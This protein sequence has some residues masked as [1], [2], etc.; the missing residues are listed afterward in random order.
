M[1]P[2]E[3]KR[4]NTVRQLKKCLAYILVSRRQINFAIDRAELVRS[5]SSNC[6]DVLANLQT[7][8]TGFEDTTQIITAEVQNIRNKM[9]R[10][11]EIPPPIKGANLNSKLTRRQRDMEKRHGIRFPCNLPRTDTSGIKS[12]DSI[13]IILTHTTY[14]PRKPKPNTRKQKGEIAI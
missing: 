10:P 4:H 5:T 6:E 13:P 12:D 3:A 8:R 1:S 7:L 9:E 14:K 2:D 11:R